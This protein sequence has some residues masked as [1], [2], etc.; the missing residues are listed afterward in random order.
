MEHPRLCRTEIE[1]LEAAIRLAERAADRLDRARH[2]RAGSPE[3]RR[4]DADLAMWDAADDARKAAQLV[5]NVTHGPPRYDEPGGD[6]ADDV[7]STA[8]RGVAP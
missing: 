3:Q 1:A 4:A 7:E 6:P 5:R 8:E 2:N